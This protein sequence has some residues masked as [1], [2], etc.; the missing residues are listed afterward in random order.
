MGKG[1]SCVEKLPVAQENAPCV[2]VQ[3]DAP[4]NLSTFPDS[5]GG[6]TKLSNPVL[7]EGTRQGVEDKLRDKGQL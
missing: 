1:Q 6:E 3:M 7:W 4:Y 2:L 5:H